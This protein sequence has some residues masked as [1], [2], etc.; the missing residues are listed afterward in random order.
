MAAP[1]SP[2]QI[3]FYV[4]SSQVST[5][6]GLSGGVKPDSTQLQLIGQI[7][8]QGGTYAFL[9]GIDGNISGNTFTASG[10]ARILRFVQLCYQWGIRVGIPCGDIN[11]NTVNAIY[12][13][14]QT[15]ATNVN[16]TID[17]VNEQE[18]WREGYYSFVDV[19]TIM[20]AWNVNLAASGARTHCY[21]GHTKVNGDSYGEDFPITS[22]VS[23]GA[24]MTFTVDISGAIDPSNYRFISGGSVELVGVS[25]FASNPNGQYVMTAAT[26]NTFQ[27]THTAGAGSYSGGATVSSVYT[28]TTELRELQSLWDVFHIHCY[29][30]I[31]Y[32]GYARRRVREFTA[33]VEVSWIISKESTT[34]S[35][36]QGNN[37]SGNMNM[38]QDAAGIA[39]FPVKGPDKDYKYVTIDTNALGYVPSQVTSATMYFNADAQ[40]SVVANVT[41][42]GVTIFTITMNV[43]RAVENGSRIMVYAGA[44]Q[45]SALLAGSISLS[46]SYAY[47]D[48]LP[49][50]SSLTY[51]WTVVSAPGGAVTSFTPS[52]AVLNPTF[53][54]SAAVTGDYV[55][56]LTV[57]DGDT[58]S[59]QEMSLFITAASGAMTLSVTEFKQ[60]T[61]DGDCDGEAQATIVGGVAPYTYTWSDG[62][63]VG[64]TAS[65]TDNLTGLCAGLI[66]CT[67]VDSTGGTALIASD[68]TT[69]TSPPPLVV[70]LVP[71]NPTCAGGSDGQI[72]MTVSGGSPLGIATIVWRRNTVV[73]VPA[74]DYNPV[75]LNLG[76]YEVTVT[77]NVGCIRVASTN[78]YEPV[79]MTATSVIQNPSCFGFNDGVITITVSGGTGTY[80]YD[81][82]DP[83]TGSSFIPPQI[84][85]KISGLSA[86]NYTVIV[87]D[88]NG[89]TQNFTFSVANPVPITVTITPI[90][91]TDFCIGGTTDFQA[92]ASG[93][94]VPYTYAWIPTTDISP[95]T[96]DLTTFTPTTA[97]AY[98]YTCLVTDANGCVGSASVGG[99][100]SA[101]F[102]TV[103]I[104][105]ASGILGSCPGDSIDLTVTNA[106]DFGDL[107]WST[108]ETTATITVD[109]ADNF[110][111]TGTDPTIGGCFNSASINIVVTPT[112]IQLIGITNNACGGID[113]A[114]AVN[115]TTFG[116]CPA[117][118]WVWTDS[119]GAVVGTTEDIS[120]LPSGIY[121][122]VA[123]DD[124][125]QT[126]TATYTIITSSPSLA[127][128]YTNIN[129][130]IG[131]SA[132]A[133]VSGG[134]APY[135]YVWTDPNGTIYL[136]ATIDDLFVQGI[137]RV[138]C[139]DANGCIAV[140]IVCISNVY[141]FG[142]SECEFKCFLQQMS[143]CQADKVY[144]MVVDERGGVDTCVQK[145]ELM[146]AYLELLECYYPE[147]A[148]IKQGNFAYYVLTINSYVNG[149]TLVINLLGSRVLSYTFDTGIP[150]A[151]NLDNIVAA[152]T[153]AGQSAYYDTDYSTYATLVIEAPTIG[154]GWNCVTMDITNTGSNI[155][156]LTTNGFTGGHDTVVADPPCLTDAGIKNIIEQM[157]CLCGCDC[158]NLTTLTNDNLIYT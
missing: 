58:T 23:A 95:T 18:F 119:L 16:E 91:I 83:A 19:R 111:V 79:A 28:A 128:T 140:D 67:V 154:S 110:S 21:V 41:V 155:E 71:T 97:G 141:S 51:A 129:G 105:V 46:D 93:G 90:G 158:N 102:A 146:E 64:P 56:R 107:L 156:I 103:P 52:A 48:W 34:A 57:T 32:Y 132:T 130:S 69:I 82:L 65:L 127:I 115:V 157:K 38:G 147:G 123:T 78:I 33:P 62:T 10:K 125:G 54:F 118:T 121:T 12:D 39:S 144:K 98:T 5:Y 44:D 137:Y 4:S 139:T 81:W 1:N 55:L 9:Y 135:A 22:V 68:S 134:T 53:N 14:N 72:V 138:V 29:S 60:T 136:G 6:I 3:Y 112:T 152:I 8:S 94:V 59:F 76:L 124:N 11:N 153:L 96:G 88:S 99:T 17:L 109:Y 31:P 36:P 13:F 70:T 75:G 149:G 113:N 80:T 49:I 100:I 42:V 92:S 63:I 116:G 7:Y 86:N 25:G 145:T 87:T 143:C 43:G 40:A 50:G 106:G 101:A 131:G 108:S 85:S 122:V 148:T 142:M 47:D 104:I 35:P 26:A 2:T 150:F 84:A 66:S 73:F 151:Q 61:C 133:N 27:I 20:T 126:A 114:G 15:F 24:T 117:Y 89:C 45:T 120:G 74:D 30:L 77:D 37:F